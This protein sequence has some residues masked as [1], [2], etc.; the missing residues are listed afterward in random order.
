M[1]KL[2]IILL[3]LSLTVSAFAESIMNDI[4]VC[5][6]FVWGYEYA[7]NS[8]NKYDKNTGALIAKYTGHTWAATGAC[9]TINNVLWVSDNGANTISV[10]NTATGETIRTCPVTSDDPGGMALDPIT[11][12]MFVGMNS[13][14]GNVDKIS[15]SDC[16][17]LTT[18]TMG[19]DIHPGLLIYDPH[20]QSI[21]VGSASTSGYI[22]EIKIATGDITYYAVG[23][24]PYS[25]AY[26]PLDNSI[27]V[28][29]WTSSN[30]LI[31]QVNTDTGVVTNYDVSTHPLATWSNGIVYASGKKLLYISRYHDGG[32]TAYTIDPI[33]KSFNP[34]NTDLGSN[35]GYDPV[36]EM[37]WG[38][39]DADNLVNASARG[40]SKYLNT[41]Y[42]SLLLHFDESDAVFIDKSFLNSTVTNSGVTYTESGK[43][44]GAGVF[45]GASTV[46]IPYTN[47]LNFG[48][49]D[50]T[51][52]WWTNMPS[53]AALNAILGQVTDGSFVGF[54]FNTGIM[55]TC[56]G[57]QACRF[58]ADLTAASLF[59]GNWHYIEISR[60][61][62]VMYMSIDGV[63]KATS[64]YAD[65]VYTF[66]PANPIS[67][68]SQNGVNLY[69]GTIDEL[70]IL[71]GKGMHTANFTPP[72]VPWDYS[73]K[74][75]FNQSGSY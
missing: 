55:G 69:K 60:V 61:K 21:A 36:T 32:E 59:D 1:R 73:Q 75:F 62:T 50:F 71:K 2:F 74:V 70:L 42:D 40:I 52:S 72:T 16:T 9:D 4:T 35:L 18:Y 28:A 49:E 63:Q 39:K 3:A 68:G 29:N 58:Q 25:L 12:A 54:I 8:V 51:I 23:L 15:L 45:D 66:L 10:M 37:V 19:N 46:T 31:A 30:T 13:A 34:I 22:A 27:W 65:V 47:L 57:G 38:V 41:N 17:I 5:G 64:Y 67:I 11:P 53:P 6:G 56:I 48:I 14:A 20:T 26:V 7:N 44:G 43:F 24:T 33:T